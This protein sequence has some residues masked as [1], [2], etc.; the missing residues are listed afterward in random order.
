MAVELGGSHSIQVTN[1]SKDMEKSD[2]DSSGATKVAPTP[3]TINNTFARRVL[4]LAACKLLRRFR[5]HRGVVLFLSK[6]K[7]VKS[8]YFTHPSEASSMRFVAEN[9][10]IPVPKVY[11]SF[12]HNGQTYIV[13]ERIQGEL[14]AHVWESWSTEKQTK[15]LEQLRFFIQELRSLTQL[16]TVGIANVDGG[17]LYDGRI[18][19]QRFGPFQ[20]VQ[21]FHRFLR[22]GLAREPG[23]D[24]EV[25]QM[26]ER[27]DGPWPPP[28]FTHGDLTSLNILVRGDKIVGV[29]DW[30]TA[31]WYPSYW[32][33]TTACQV[34][35][36]N[37]YWREH[38]DS[39]LEAMP[40]E[41]TM[42]QVR[43]RYFGD[44]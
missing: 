31:G 11:C 10:S 41:L 4:T 34:N 38:I 28:I 42:D 15:I 9:T 2:S 23:Y 21:E 7:C 17:S 40:E 27:Q 19:F 32:E 29:V 25:D 8:E 12:V 26:M 13:M 36:R 14:L 22:G 5:P 20:T 16:E 18:G 44:V 37:S 35:P 24:I 6:H 30:E 39:F 1:Y 3:P 43:Q 33:Y